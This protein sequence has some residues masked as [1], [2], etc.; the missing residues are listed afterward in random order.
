MKDEDKTGE[1]LFTERKNMMEELNKLRMLFETTAQG[2]VY[3]NADGEIMSANPAA[4]RILGLSKEQMQGRTS[5]DPGW[6]TIHEDGTDFP[7]ETHPSMVALKTGKK[8]KDVIMGVFNPPEDRYRWIKINAVPQFMPG[9]EKPYRVCTIFD[10]ITGRKQ[11]GEELYKAHDELE[12][13]VE[14]R[15]AELTIANEKLKREIERYRQAEEELRESE[16]KY[17][18]LFESSIEG[19]GISKKNRVVTA[20]RAL[21]DMFGYENPGEFIK[22][23][24][25]DLVAPEDRQMISERI[26]KREK[27][28]PVAPYYEF[29]IIRKDGKIRELEI[30]TT[31]ITIKSEKY[32][33]STFRDITGR[34][35]IE[36]ALRKSEERYDLAVKGSTDGLWDWPDT[37]KDKVWWSPRIFELLGYEDGEFESSFSKFEELLHPEDRGRAVGAV[38]AHLKEQAPFDVEYRLRTKSGEYRWFRSRGQALWPENDQLVRMAGSI[39]DITDRK[40]AEKALR[41]SER[42][43]G[44]IIESS[45][46]GIYIFNM[47]EQTNIY[48]NPQYTELTGYTMESLR[49]LGRQGF[50]QLNYPDDLEAILKH[51]EAMRRAE[52]GEVLEVEYRFR[53]AEGK[54]IWCLSRDT[55]FHRGTGGKVEQVIGTFLDIT[56]Q[57]IAEE[58]LRKAH[59]ELE[60]RVE[61]RTEEL[62][63]TNK[64][65]K[66][67][68]TDRMRAKEALQKSMREMSIMNRISNIFLTNPDDKMYGE[69]L[70]VVLEAMQSKYGVFGY[71][72]GHGTLVCPSMTKD[73]WDQCRISD[74]E[75]VFPRETW[76]GIWGRAMIEKKSLYLNK[77]FRVPDGHVPVSRAL[78]VPI[79]HQGEVIG[80]LLVGNKSTDYDES[81]RVFLEYIGGYIAP[82]L[83]ARLQRGCHER[84]IKAANEALKH[85]KEAADVANRA[86]STFLANM[87]HELRTPLNSVL[88]FS[89][90]LEME[91]DALSE[92]QL[93]LV[94]HIRSSGE[95]L[96]EMVNDVL[97]ISKIEAG[98]LEIEKKPFELNLLISRVLTSVKYLADRKRMKVELNMDTDPGLIEADEVRLKQVLYNLLSNAVKFTE[99]GKRVGVRVSAKDSQAMIEV[100][101][102]GA[103]IA[104]EDFKKIFNPFEQIRQGGQESR[105]GP[106]LGLLFR[107]G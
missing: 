11:A 25:L 33:Q 38:N 23:P 41:E 40:K 29:K 74:K 61:E 49:A 99:S 107:G 94:G 103:G 8:V 55:V 36:E 2:I 10:D 76:G 3:Q 97:D 45:L 93:Q 105:R 56:D 104:E 20:N 32:V 71:I 46:N 98:K 89:Q 83:G 66:K 65:L 13:R 87:S 54:W 15:T 88:G 77:P 86:K 43:S 75:I 18:S 67:E 60:K 4:G 106:V 14:E 72:D 95:H 31:E 44:K 69:V 82:V 64:Q 57:K 12:Q 34:K 28:V 53:T 19:I 92:E 80:N 84:E 42:F 102:E 68:I 21:L 5:T 1:Q 79:I 90:L 59:D 50:Q 78:D 85:A 22:V 27:G 30:S 26:E 37:G 7:G 70:P 96:L 62:S 35:K 39:Q 100:W 73:I 6:K 81:D 9:G 17:R 24:L 51:I 58:E 48:I 16:D 47:E 91:P 101:D 63:S 52:D